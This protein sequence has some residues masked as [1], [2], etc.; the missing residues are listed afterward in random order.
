VRGHV[1]GV[2]VLA[3]VAVAALVVFAAGGA[4]APVVLA[5]LIPSAV[6]AVSAAWSVRALFGL[7]APTRE[8][9]RRA[10]AEVRT[11]RALDPRESA[12]WVLLH[13]HLV[14]LELG[15]SPNSPHNLW[16]E[17]GG[18]PNPK[19]KLEGALHDLVCSHRMTLTDTQNAIA[20]DWVTTYRQVLGT[21]PAG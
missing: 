16:P 3:S 14:S 20:R 17:P 9:R 21:A 4:P 10:S 6:G 18:S 1:G 11:A 7:D 19:D 2:A 15:G 13:D 12:R 5:V 8:L